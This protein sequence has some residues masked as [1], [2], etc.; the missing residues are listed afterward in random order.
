MDYQLVKLQEIDT[1]HSDPGRVPR[2][3]EVE[4][5]EDLVDFCIPG[6]VVSVTGIVKTHLLENTR[7]NRTRP[8]QA[9]RQSA[10][11]QLYLEANAVQNLRS[12]SARN[13]GNR[14]DVT[15]FSQQDYTV[16]REVAYTPA[17]FELLVASL[18][19]AIC[20]HELV[21]VSW[22]KR[23]ERRHLDAR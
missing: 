12:S 10:L 2:T 18:C 1:E 11:H 20:G 8:G 6:D 16:I 9:P 3:L 4:L 22:E 15:I 5:R 17:C 19:P 13:L 21:K 23:V 7:N 14:S